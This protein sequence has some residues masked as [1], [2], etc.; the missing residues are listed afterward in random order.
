MTK[1]SLQLFTALLLLCTTLA[2]AEK[3]QVSF[4]KDASEPRLRKEVTLEATAALFAKRLSQTLKQEVKVVPFEKADA[5]TI[6]LITREAAAGGRLHQ[7]S[8][9]TSQRQFYHPLPCDRQGQK[10]C[11]SA[12]EPGCLGVLLPRKLFPAEISGGGYR[13]AR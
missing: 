6:F 7:S 5:E 10:E 4:L 1:L 2:G 11:L 12:D 3:F 13:S 8:C 9:R